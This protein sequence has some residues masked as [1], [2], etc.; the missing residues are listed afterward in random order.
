MK[1]VVNTNIL[2]TFFWKNSTT[3]EIIRQRK[4]VLLSPMFAKEELRKYSLE[5]Q[6][7][8]R[9]SQKEFEEI[10]AELATTVLFV[11]LQEY[12]HLLK[13]AAT[14]SP[15]KNDIDFVALAIAHNCPLWTNDHKLKEQI[16]EIE[17]CTTEEII[18]LIF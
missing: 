13:R 5:I 17:V 9:C 7:K 18:K 3:R 2:F 10:L 6:E 15:D 14:I 16:I 12:V 4:L 8:T 1:V 11:P